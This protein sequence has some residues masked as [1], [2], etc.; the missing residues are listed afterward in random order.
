VRVTP[1]FGS[2]TFFSRFGFEGVSAA[3]S[4][5]SSTSLSCSA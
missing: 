5:W 4:G 3:A 1:V 2:R